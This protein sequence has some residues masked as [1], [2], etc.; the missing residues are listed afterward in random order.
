[1]SPREDSPQ[2]S[3]HPLPPV[4]LATVQPVELRCTGVRWASQAV[5]PPQL[6]IRL[7]PHPL[8]PASLATVQPV[9]RRCTRFR[10]SSHVVA[11]PQ[12]PICFSPCASTTAQP[13]VTDSLA[14]RLP[15]EMASRGN[16][17]Q[18]QD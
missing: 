2:S 7:S 12:L 6:P 4:S 18:L 16:T 13:S 5:P 15:R 1:M 8:P 9:E 3:P 11:S 10:W 17:A 14:D